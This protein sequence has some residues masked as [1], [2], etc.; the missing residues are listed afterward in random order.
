MI[1][2]W[3]IAFIAL[4]LIAYMLF[5]PKAPTTKI[6]QP[7]MIEKQVDVPVD[8]LPKAYADQI[9]VFRSTQAA[10]RYEPMTSTALYSDGVVLRYSNVQV[11]K[12]DN[13]I[14]TEEAPFAWREEAKIKTEGVD[15]ILDLL[16]SFEGES[17]QK[18]LQEPVLLEYF[19]DGNKN[20]VLIEGQNTPNAHKLFTEINRLISINTLPNSI[21]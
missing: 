9:P 14:S 10:D 2:V 1:Y 6:E 18:G 8:S 17:N 16:K 5:K 12:K 4:A 19:L 3:I 20:S 21:D 11:V 13:S 15:K 7:T